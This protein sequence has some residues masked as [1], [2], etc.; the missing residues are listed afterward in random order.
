MSFYATRQSFKIA[1][2]DVYYIDC[3]KLTSKDDFQI[4]LRH[5]KRYIPTCSWGNHDYYVEC[6]SKI[7]TVE[8]NFNNWMLMHPQAKSVPLNAKLKSGRPINKHLIEQHEFDTRR[9]GLN[10][11]DDI[12]GMKSIYLFL[13][14]FQFCNRK[15]IISALMI[16]KLN[17]IMITEVLEFQTEYREN[18]EK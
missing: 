5:Y 1:N 10:F 9:S 11:Q 12:L 15:L 6:I 18:L 13:I 2:E 17:R 7:W 8:M 3:K 4:Q 14:Y 16:W